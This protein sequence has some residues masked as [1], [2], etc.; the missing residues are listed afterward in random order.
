MCG[1][2]GVVGAADRHL[3]GGMLSRIAH[4]GPDDEG[5]YITSTSS[6]VVVGL[7]HRRLSII[8][9]SPAGHEPISDFTGRIWLTFNGEIYNFRQLRTEL[10]SLGHRFRTGTDAEVIIYGYMEWGYQCLRRFNGMFAFAIWDSRNESLFIARDRLGIKPV[11]YSDTPSGFA[12]ASEIKA[13]LAIPGFERAVDPGALDQFMTFLWVPDPKTVFKG[14]FKLPPAHYLVWSNGRT[15]THEYWDLQFDEDASISEA[16]WTGR[17]RESVANSV[18]AQMVS[19]VP[20]GAFLSGGLDSSSVVALMSGS[21]GP[22]ERPGR[23]TTYSFGFRPEDLRYDI[24]GDDLKYAR[25]VGKQF[26]TDYHESYLDPKVADLLP[27]L[28]YHL[29]EPVADPAIITSYLICR[30]ARERL[31]VLLSGMG[32]DELFGGYPRHLAVQLAEL[33]NLIPSR[34]SRPLVGSLQGSKPG[35]FTAIRRNLKK[36]GRSAALPERERYLGFGTYFSASDKQELYSAGFAAE[37]AGMDP[38]VMH[39]KYFDRVAG[40]TFLNQM[41]YVDIKTYLPCLNL[42]YTDKTSMAASTEVRVPLLDHELVELSGRI[43]SALKLRRRTGKYILKQAAESW[44]PR[45]IIHRKKAGFSAPIRA[46]LVRDLKD[47]V[48]DLLS[49][50]SIRSRG[51]FEYPAV[52][53]LIDDNLSGREDNSLKVFQLL[54]LELWHRAFIDS[55]DSEQRCNPP[56][57][58]SRQTLEPAAA[59]GV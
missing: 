32:G 12:F 15:E 47:A 54:T 50:S 55:A 27:M 3:L 1:I 17:L 22:T 9:V 33:Y 16:E 56:L 24:I 48:E 40:Q 21:S 19:D 10:E 11:Y 35:R 28:V 8:D 4:R 44:L 53:K 37:T 49:E 18:R 2:C 46:W 5:S 30:T 7:G 25:V 34:I 31:T 45:D 59:K 29:D 57:Q 51:Y 58:V 6:G 38:Y 13:F 36:L 41:L 43:P 42:T 26:N 52:R 14:V 23:V 39:R 20:L